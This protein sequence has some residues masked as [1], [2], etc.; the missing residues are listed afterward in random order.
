MLYML[1]FKI[2]YVMGGC[3]IVI[4]N[5]KIQNKCLILLVLISILFVYSPSANAI[6]IIQGNV[7]DEQ[8][9]PLN[10]VKITLYKNR[11]QIV[12]V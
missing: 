4:R 3:K 9:N 7:M 12:T 6:S 1:K 8:G 10:E 2:K 11:D 5:R